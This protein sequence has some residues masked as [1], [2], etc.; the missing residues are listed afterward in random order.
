M[1]WALIMLLLL[2]TPAYAEDL[3][4]IEEQEVIEEVVTAD[5]LESY[6]ETVN[7]ILSDQ[8]VTIDTLAET[9]QT[10]TEEVHE[11]EEVNE[12]PESS[13]ED[14]EIPVDGF[15]RVVPV[16]E[17]SVQDLTAQPTR[18]AANTVYQTI[19]NNSS[20][21]SYL[22]SMLGKLG[23]SDDYVAWQDTNASYV[24][25]YGDIELE[26]GMFVSDGCDY[27]RYYRTQQTNWMYETGH[28]TLNLNPAGYGVLS[29]LGDYP[30]LGDGNHEQ[31][32]F[33]EFVAILA[34]AIYSF[35]S[36]FSF[37]LRMRS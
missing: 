25:A 30:L 6:E 13:E 29:S 28:S 24:L 26:N 9:V 33:Y 7:Q 21:A 35:R 2:S 15:L 32:L 1:V 27:I 19:T 23:W 4:Q 36:V 10:L 17:I 14:T 22:S 20:G 8:N 18:S 31:M 3:E 5:D 12:E 34:I 16:D 37:L 11:Q